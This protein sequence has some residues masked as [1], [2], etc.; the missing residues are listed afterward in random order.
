M[1]DTDATA[2]SDPITVTATDSLGNSSNQTI[3]VTING[4]PTIGVP[5]AVAEGVGQ[6]EAISGV[7]LAETGSAGAPETFTAA[8]SDSAGDLTVSGNGATLTGNGT[9]A[10]TISGSLTQVDAALA[11]LSDTDGTAGSDT[12]TLTASDSFGNTA[13]SQTIGV[14]VNGL[15]VLTVPGAQNVV[16]G[17]VTAIGG[18]SLVETGS[19]AG[20]SFTAKLTDMNGALSVAAN[21]ATVTG[22]GTTAVTIAGSLTQVDAALASLSDGDSTAGPDT[23]T[24]N[25]VDSFGNAAAVQSIAV[26]AGTS[27]S[28]VVPPAQAVGVGKNATITGLGLSPSSTVASET[29]TATLADTHGKLTVTA[30]GAT[31]TGNGTTSLTIKGSLAQ[32]N[33][34]LAKVSDADATVGADAITVTASDSLGVIATPQ[35]LAVTVNGLP[36]IAVPGAQVAGVGKALAI[37]GV[38]I[39]ETGS[40]GLP[41]TFTTTLSDKTGNL[42]VAAS[43]A[44]VTGNGTNS[45][46]ITGSLAQVD[47]ALATLSD[48]DA[49]VGSD[50]IALKVTDSFGNAASAQ[51]IAVTANAPPVVTVPGAQTIVA[52]VSTAIS[53]VKLTETGKTTAPESF[54]ATLA[55]TNGAL[56]VTA[57]GATVTGNGT[58]T[59]TITGSLTQVDAALASLS[60]TDATAGVDAISLNAADSLGN[61]AAQQTIAVTAKNST[62]LVVIPAAVV[63]GVGKAATITGL[64]LS[65]ST[66]VANEIFTT[67][68]ADTTGDLTVTA[69][70]ATVTGNGT[71]SVTISGSLAQVDAALAKVSDTNG[72]AGSDPITV[73][74]NDSLGVS[75]T[76]KSLGVTVNGLPSITVPGAQ[77]TGIGKALA[78]AGVTIS[79]SGS[80]GSPE[81]FTATLSDKYGDLSVTAS[82]ATVT[83]NGTISLKLSGS[84]AQVDAALATLSDTDATAAN[85]TIGLK[86][87]DSFGNA[88]A[89][90][91]I[92]LTVN[93]APVLTVPGPE[94]LVSG[95]AKAITGI[96]LT[97]TGSTAAPESFTATL[98]DT[99]GALTVAANGATVTGNGTTAVTIAG[100]LTQVDAALASLSDTD[101]TIG[102]DTI[103]LNAGD[104]FGNAAAPASIAVTVSGSGATRADAIGDHLSATLQLLNQYASQFGAS[105][106]DYSGASDKA[107]GLPGGDFLGEHPGIVE[108]R[109]LKYA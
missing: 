41:E 11:S 45:L 39:A 71:T 15:P 3:G 7:T 103:S 106:A 29:F 40:T 81:T 38:T 76:L 86:V 4:L 85:D 63:L 59:V 65:P 72:T 17:V 8:L 74:A 35:S 46:Q 68:L 90:Q 104:S 33:A 100:S 61:A 84:L 47:A 51:S 50:T 34:A 75:A 25:A 55:D 12:I 30:N 64:S 105:A 24:V 82:G 83:G 98:A 6:T 108:S 10:L 9:T 13:S 28:I 36:S 92:G 96:K 27:L 99:N 16:S 70:G 94:S 56:S 69:G 89:S 57:N 44:T 102:A 23:I 37:G 49:T 58:T 87:S 91:A 26:T 32:V 18:V 42:S 95:V 2:G 21:G 93:G 14:T 79:E 67:T 62:L 73:N 78:I 31:V 77:R 5:A 107:L 43:G 80:T 60:D 19:T 109:H 22:N 48:T 97:E 1:T 101:A 54:T 53:G 52:G 20:E 88:S 66:T